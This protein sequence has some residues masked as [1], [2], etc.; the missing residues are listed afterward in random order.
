MKIF[1]KALVLVIVFLVLVSILP[2]TSFAGN[3]DSLPPYGYSGKGDDM[4][5]FYFLMKTLHSLRFSIK[6]SCTRL[7]CFTTASFLNI[8][9]V[10]RSMYLF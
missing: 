9:F 6:D 3:N 10:P 4:E 5:Q 8:F 2:C 1:L 7:L